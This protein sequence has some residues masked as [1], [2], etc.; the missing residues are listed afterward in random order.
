LLSY[1]LFHNF[2]L[3]FI[4]KFLPITNNL[5]QISALFFIFLVMKSIKFRVNH[6]IRN[7]HFIIIFAL[8][9]VSY[10][11]KDY[12][13]TL[14][15][16]L[17]VGTLLFKN[18]YIS[19]ENLKKYLDLV[20]IIIFIIAIIEL[21]LGNTYHQFL[22]IFS[23]YLISRSRYSPTELEIYTQIGAYRGESNYILPFI[24]YRVSSIFLE[25]LGL[26]YFSII[27]LGFYRS[28]DVH[29][30]TLIEMKNN[31]WRYILIISLI[32]LS[33]TR[34]SYL[35]FIVIFLIPKNLM[36]LKNSYI[37]II[38]TIISF[39]ILVSSTAEIDSEFYRRIY[40]TIYSLTNLKTIFNLSKYNFGILDSGYGGIMANLG[41][42][43]FIYIF[44]F[45]MNS[46]NS[47]DKKKSSI[48]FFNFTVLYLFYFA[49][50][51]GAIF[52]IKTFVLLIILC[53]SI[54]FYSP[55]IKE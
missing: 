52:S 40:P 4:N 37:A 15:Y 39:I 25:P 53:N 34:S 45:L 47:L 36:V 41:I 21:V 49:I 51:G 38:L 55:N 7:F 28:L 6:I 19:V 22:D 27:C 43:G 9:V 2:F 8:I 50:F 23:Y 13:L 54:C 24:N 44:S 46:N 11:Q 14:I 18:Y 5:Y 3:V 33:D 48:Y 10:F 31:Y 20:L 17:V 12:D 1:S 32:I 16:A 42:L 30:N 35:I 26:A 29:S